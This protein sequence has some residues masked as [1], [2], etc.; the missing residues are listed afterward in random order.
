MSAGNTRRTHCHVCDPAAA[1]SKALEINAEGARYCF[2]CHWRAK[3]CS[4]CGDLFEPA[5]SK[6]ERCDAC[7]RRETRPA[8]PERDKLAAIWAR[9][10]PLRGTLGETYLLH[11]RCVIPPPDSDLRFL[12]G[13]DRYPPSLCALVSNTL[14]NEPQSLHFTRLKSDG[15]GRLDRMLLRGHAKKN[16]C[17]RLWPDEAVT[18]GLAISE[19]VETA[20]SAAHAF[21]PVW[22]TVDAGNMALFPVLDG[23]ATLM[24]FADNDEAGLKAARACGSRWAAA[25]REA[26]LV[27]PERGDVN[28]VVAA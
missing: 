26:R 12:P 3:P 21:Q 24:L 13:S 18:H 7:F 4:T 1:K 19:G 5:G 11:R 2:R 15:S 27:I 6:H 8:I 10:V 23:I 17:I 9:T 28:D 16:G 20:L 25:G 22:A 14:T